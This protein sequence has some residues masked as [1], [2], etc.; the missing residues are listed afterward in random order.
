[1]LSMKSIAEQVALINRKALG[2]GRINR[3]I[4]GL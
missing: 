1:M 2:L 4:R 3:A